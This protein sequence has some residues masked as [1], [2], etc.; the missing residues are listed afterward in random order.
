MTSQTKHY[1]I[2]GGALI[3][4]VVVGIVLYKHYAAS[5]GAS[6][7]TQD[8]S[9]QDALALLE[10]NAMNSPYQSYGSSAAG[11]VSLPSPAPQQSLADQIASL[12]QA[13][14]FASPVSTPTGA[15]TPSAGSSSSPSVSPSPVA[16]RTVSPAPPQHAALLSDEPATLKMEHEEFVS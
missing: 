16:P 7:A 6:Q 8:Q 10:A 14:G 11:G 3:V 4:A 13:F 12:E 15:S 1:L 5:A 2:V 9:N